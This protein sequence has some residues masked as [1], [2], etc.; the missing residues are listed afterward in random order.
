MTDALYWLFVQQSAWLASATGITA[1]Y[2]MGSKCW[3]A[4]WIGLAGQGFWV[5]LAVYTEQYGLLIAAF[6]YGAMYARAGVKWYRDREHG[7]G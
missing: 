5:T 6:F 1:A 2:F 4:P 7:H 3:W